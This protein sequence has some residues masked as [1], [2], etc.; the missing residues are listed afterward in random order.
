MLYE[1]PL[2]FSKRSRGVKAV[3][4]P[5]HLCSLILLPYCQGFLRALLPPT[6]AVQ[7]SGRCSQPGSAQVPMSQAA[8]AKIKMHPAQHKTLLPSFPWWACNFFPSP[9]YWA[10]QPHGKLIIFE[11]ST[12]PLNGQRALFP[13]ELQTGSTWGKPVPDCPSSQICLYTAQ[14]SWWRG[15]PLFTHKVVTSIP[16]TLLF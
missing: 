15:N 9:P 2:H 4:F 3:C 16:Y 10:T 12:P 8:A 5:L 1:A 13:Y 11:L 6:D 14:L 7:E